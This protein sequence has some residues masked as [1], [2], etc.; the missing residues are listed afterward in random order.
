MLTRSGLPRVCD[1][2]TQGTPAEAGELMT[3]DVMQDQEL[4]EYAQLVGVQR[5]DLECQCGHPLCP[6]PKLFPAVAKYT[7]KAKPAKLV[8]SNANRVT[9]IVLINRDGTLTVR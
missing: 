2:S 9:R 4:D 1:R 7:T 6:L 3:P 8:Q 5:D